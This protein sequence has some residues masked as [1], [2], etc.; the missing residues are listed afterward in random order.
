MQKCVA[1]D[2]NLTGADILHVFD[3]KIN[4]LTETTRLP[5]NGRNYKAEI[6]FSEI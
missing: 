6:G 4:N 2:T 5:W 3:I 1:T